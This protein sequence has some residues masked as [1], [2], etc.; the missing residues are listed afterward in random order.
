M[1]I[2]CFLSVSYFVSFELNNINE[3]FI[4]ELWQIGFISSKLVFYLVLRLPVT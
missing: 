2:R 4:K 3:F 1:I